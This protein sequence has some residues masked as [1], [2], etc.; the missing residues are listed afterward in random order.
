MID[1]A[2]IGGGVNGCGIARDAAGRGLSRAARRA[3]RSRPR[4]LV[5]LHQADPWRPALP[6]ILRVPPGARSAG[7]ARSAAARG[8]AHH[9][10]A[11]LRPAA[12]QGPAPGLVLRLGLFLYDH[13]GGAQDPAADADARP[14]DRSRRRAAQAA[15]HARPS[16]IP[17]AG[18][19]MRAWSCST[20]ATPPSAAPTSAP[21]PRC[22]ERAARRTWPG[23]STL[24]R[25]DGGTETVECARAR[26]CRR[27]LGRHVFSRTCCAPNARAA[28]RLVKG[29]HIV[30]AAALRSRP[31][32][33]LPERRRPHHASPFPTSRI[34]R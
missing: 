6:R 14:R 34:S 4:H 20:P 19:T 18:W 28:V 31:L 2:V 26:Q 30:V 25:Q 9:L 27:A 11:A 22:I 3:G 7:R 8:A 21:A 5:G 17:I 32:L 13:L 29:S 33:H 23:S 15:L 24:Q 10:A 16:N 12:P 1:L